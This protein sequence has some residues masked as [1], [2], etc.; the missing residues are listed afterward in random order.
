MNSKL[1]SL[2]V[3]ARERTRRLIIPLLFAMA[4][5]IPPQ[6]WVT[7]QFNHGYAG[8]FWPFWIHDYFRFGE[9]DGVELPE[10]EH[11]WFVFYLWLFTLL[12]ARAPAPVPPRAAG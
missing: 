5:I 11:L 12:L 7:L 9:I 8:G 1:G 3:F 10:W 6:S 2:R 4:I